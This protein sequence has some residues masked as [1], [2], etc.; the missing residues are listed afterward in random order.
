MQRELDAK[1]K[2][3]PNLSVT[4][5]ANSANVSVSHLTRILRGEKNMSLDIG[6]RLAKTLRLDIRKKTLLFN[7]IQLESMDPG[8]ERDELLQK[9]EKHARPFPKKALPALTPIADWLYLA[10]LTL[11]ESKSGAIN[12]EQVSKAFGVSEEMAIAVLQRLYAHKLIAASPEYIPAHFEIP[13]DVP[14]P[15]VKK[16]HQQMLSKAMQVVR[17]RDVTEREF[18]GLMLPVN[19]KQMGRAK[20]L[21]RE[22]L[23]YF[24]AEMTA[25]GGDDIYYLN[26]NFFPLGE[27]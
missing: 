8:R 22:F 21:I 6:A 27:S 23:E 12:P 11:A 25:A 24:E 26:M 9:I 18:Q 19:P 20:E 3:S 2:K 15:D 7:L 16:L 13:S 14:S 17:S 5:I 10:T 4:S 1:I